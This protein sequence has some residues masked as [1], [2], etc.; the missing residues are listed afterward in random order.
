MNISFHPATENDIKE[1]HEIEVAS[2][3]DPW[4]EDS[5]RTFA[6][7]E[8]IR[9]LIV[10]RENLSGDAETG[11]IVGYF[12]LQYVLDEA[13]IAI[14]AVKSKYRRQGLGRR[15]LDEVRCFC[16]G[17]NITTIHLE[18]RSE[19]EA[20]IHLYRAYGFEEVGR[21]RNYYEAPKDDA[22]LFRLSI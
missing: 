16:Q 11:E 6:H 8:T 18:V 15:M 10:A 21:R 14:I 3:P 20:A 7:D 5:L 12:A 17:K 4:S 19:N 1:I 2:F 13:E 9:M 22:I